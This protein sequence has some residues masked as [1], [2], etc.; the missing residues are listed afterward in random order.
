MAGR[1]E[2]AP[3]TVWRFMGALDRWDRML[4][5]IDAISRVDGGGPAIGVGA[6]FRVRQPGLAPAVY[7]V[8]DWR[9]NAGFT[10]QAR[11]VGV[12]TVAAHTLRPDGTGTQV[13]LSITWTGPGAWPARALFTR[14]T[15]A[16]LAGELAAFARLATQE[17]S[18]PGGSRRE[19][20]SGDGE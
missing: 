5:T 3:E 11:S 15:R 8:T 18:P 6:R 14:K 7:E 4:P 1:V 9:P 2:A 17:Q 12:T 16:F 13:G 10:W 19:S 20:R